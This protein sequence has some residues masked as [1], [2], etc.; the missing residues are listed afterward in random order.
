VDTYFSVITETVYEQPHSFRTEKIVKALAAGH[1]FI[2]AANRGFYRDLHNLGFCT[3]DSIIDESFDSI[4]LPQDR[5]DRICE[6]VA[7]LCAQDL[8]SFLAQCYTVCKYNQQ[9]L[10][11]VRGTLQHSLP[12]RFF[13]F[14]QQYS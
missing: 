4:D 12:D 9:H 6:I 3:F 14:L 8:A 11:E 2:V 13:K 5:M 1:P 10:L 7:D